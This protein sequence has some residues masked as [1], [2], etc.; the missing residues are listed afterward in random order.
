MA[1]LFNNYDPFKS[2]SS[3]ETGSLGEA[4]KG[5]SESIRYSF[6]PRYSRAAQSVT[7]KGWSPKG[8]MIREAYAPVD[9]ALLNS[10]S[11]SIPNLYYNEDKSNQ[12]WES[13]A[14]QKMLGEGSLSNQA[15]QIENQANQNNKGP[16][17][18]L[19]PGSR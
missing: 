19:F 17:E 6:L 8:S 7:G 3:L 14:I 10:L 18:W 16:L 5:L 1:D 11:T 9:D 13:M 2:V 4:G 12:G 15:D